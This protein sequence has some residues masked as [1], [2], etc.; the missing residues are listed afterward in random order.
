MRHTFAACMLA[1]STWSLLPRLTPLEP[2]PG[3]Q[4]LPSLLQAGLKL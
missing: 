1:A 2:C 4:F 3:A